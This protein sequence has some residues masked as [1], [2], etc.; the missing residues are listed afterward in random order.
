MWEEEGEQKL[1]LKKTI[2]RNK[3]ENVI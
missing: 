2:K 3:K 1:K